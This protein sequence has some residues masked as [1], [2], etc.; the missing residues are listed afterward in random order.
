MKNNGNLIFRFGWG[1]LSLL[2]RSF[3]RRRW[4]DVMI[5][6]WDCFSTYFESRFWRL[7][8]VRN[9][10]STYWFSRF[11]IFNLAAVSEKKTTEFRKVHLM[12]DNSQTDKAKIME[13][14]G[15]D[16]RTSRMLSGRS[17]IWATPPESLSRNRHSVYNPFSLKSMPNS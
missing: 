17:T 13:M 15:I 5:K 12:S 8:F 10:E 9:D 11:S 2:Y 14:R 3:N 16:P 7:F 4:S 1:W 6:F